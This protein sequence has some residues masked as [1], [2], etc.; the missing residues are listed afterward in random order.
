MISALGS[1]ARISGIALYKR[2]SSSNIEQEI[3]KFAERPLIKRK[4]EEFR[5]QVAEIETVDEFFKKY[6]VLQFALSAYGME[7]EARY[8]ARIRQTMM[9]DPNDRY[10]VANRMA[11]ERYRQLAREFDFFN[12]GVDQLK[13]SNFVD[14]LVNGFVRNEFEKDAGTLNPDVTAALYFRRKAPQMTKTNQLYGDVQLFDVVKEA[15]AIPS[16]AVNQPVAQLTA[17]I[18]RDF[19]VS[20][21]GDKAYVDKFITRYLAMKDMNQQQSTSSTLTGIFG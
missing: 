20:R 3:A 14:Y 16:A 18:E 5:A 12:K 19:D 11:D 21:V 17:R 1:T 2:I 13:D 8:P 4:T 7:S 9:S 10:S 6:K 15:L